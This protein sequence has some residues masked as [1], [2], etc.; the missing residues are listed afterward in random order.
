MFPGLVLEQHPRVNGSIMGRHPQP[1]VCHAE[2]PDVHGQL[3][4][5]MSGERAS[6]RKG[7]DEPETEKQNQH[8]GGRLAGGGGRG[9]M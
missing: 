2:L 9:G 7:K 8:G 4:I 6:Q 3:Q 1:V 5:K